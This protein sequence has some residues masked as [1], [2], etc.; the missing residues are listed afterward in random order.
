MHSITFKTLPLTTNRLYATRGRIRFLTSAA[1]ANKAA[2]RREARAQYQGDPLTGPVA[3][4]IVL[5]WPNRR[6]RDQDNL[7]GL[8]DALS[9]ILWEDDSLIT[10]AFVSKRV[11][12][13]N[14]RVE[15]SFVD[16]AELTTLY[17]SA[18]L[19]E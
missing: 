8:Y 6:K 12:R 15:L 9:G 17:Q 4:R 3:V 11:D 14:P 10:D 13:D 16:S 7:K 5:W 2:M 18:I 1:K 19:G